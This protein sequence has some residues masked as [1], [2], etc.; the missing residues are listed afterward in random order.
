MTNKSLYE[1][2]IEMKID[3]EKLLRLTKYKG[4]E[5]K[6]TDHNT[7]IIKIEDEVVKQRKEKQHRWKTNNDEAWEKYKNTTEDNKELDKTWKNEK[8]TNKNWREWKHIVYKILNET[9]GKIRIT[10]NNKQGIDKEVREM[11]KEKREVRKRTKEAGEPEEK[12]RL[13]EKRKELERQITKKL[14]ERDEEKISGITKSLND[15]RNNY[16]VLWK[17]KKK[18]QRKKETAHIIKDKVGNDLKAPE[19][20]K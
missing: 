3:E 14:E 1:D 18:V 8:D 5:I 19:D 7:I 6:E 17:I 20:I 4:K 9:L 15:K 11:M 12:R 13:E 10:N 2:L 16:D